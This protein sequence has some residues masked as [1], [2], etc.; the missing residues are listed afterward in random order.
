MQRYTH[1]GREIDVRHPS[2]RFAVAGSAVVGALALVLAGGGILERVW[3]AVLFGVAAFLAWAL[4]RE[5]DPDRHLT[6]TLALVVGGSLSLGLGV[7][8][9]GAI[10]LVMAAARI[11]AR[12]TGLA[13]KTSDLVIV[14]VVATLLASDV[15]GWAGAMILAFAIV[16]DGAL[17]EPAPR[18]QAWFGVAVAVLASV[19]AWLRD[20]FEGW[21]TPDLS[22]W[23]LIGAGVL[24]AAIATQ[25]EPVTATC[26][27]RGENLH[28]VRV[29][30]ARFQTLVAA[31]LAVAVG[32]AAG[33][34]GLAAVWGTLAVAGI[35]RLISS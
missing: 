13:P 34:R 29:R 8:S 21:E 33:A 16:R 4:G 19:S 6:A 5:I 1:L 32:G 12:T 17:P 25:P 18:T 31:V 10:L 7:A 35:V 30:W 26:D 14:L 9:P 22:S 27:I 23:A 20:A 3:E 28:H 24:G 11:T 15:A 2:N